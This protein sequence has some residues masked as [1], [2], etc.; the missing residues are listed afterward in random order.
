[1]SGISVGLKNDLPLAHHLN[2]AGQ[3][4]DLELNLTKGFLKGNL[5]T[6]HLALNLQDVPRPDNAF[7]RNLGINPKAAE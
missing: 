7:E 3:N 6:A 2:K 5:P 1:M 4:T